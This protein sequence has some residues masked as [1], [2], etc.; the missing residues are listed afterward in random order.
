MPL[1][2]NVEVAADRRLVERCERHLD[3]LRFAPERLCDELR[4]LDVEPTHDLRIVRV[5]LHV[6]RSA[7]RVASPSQDW[8]RSL[9]GE[10]LV[11]D[12]QSEQP[13]RDLCCL[14]L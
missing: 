8:R 2:A 6:G 9:R 10:R 7:L 4:D 13:A 5:G 1:S 14:P 11:K 12:Q 3:E